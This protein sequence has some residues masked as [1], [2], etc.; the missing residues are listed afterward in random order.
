MAWRTLDSVFLTQPR[1][2]LNMSPFKVEHPVLRGVKPWS[3]RDEV[4]SRYFLFDNPTDGAD[5]RYP[6]E[7]K[8]RSATACLLGI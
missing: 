8:Q 1:G 5:G 6:F 4:F 7:R 2:H 3:F